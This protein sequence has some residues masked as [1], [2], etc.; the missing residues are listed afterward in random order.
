[1]SA[2]VTL[3]GVEKRYGHQRVLTVES[4]ILGAGERVVISGTNGSGK[5]T[6]L[7]LLGG[8]SSPDRG[9]VIRGDTI[10]HGRL[11]YVPQ[12]GGLYS[13][14]TLRENLSLR[15]R[16]WRRPAAEPEARWYIGELGLGPLLDK[17]PP[18][19]SGGFQR[20]ATVA[21]ALHA[22]PDWLLLDEPFYGV[23]ATRRSRLIEGLLELAKSLAMLV[24]AAPTAD[25]LPDATLTISVEQGL[26]QCVG[27]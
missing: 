24:V 5:S 14:L 25:E 16:L 7:R 9:R 17:M 8:V 12:S 15:R 26:V 2:I 4:L 18:E 22:D 11:G 20:L 3:H 19:L 1:V 6:L 21:A 23:D 13:D 10:A 27:H